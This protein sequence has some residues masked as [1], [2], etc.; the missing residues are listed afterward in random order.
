ME[1]Y[2]NAVSDKLVVVL[3]EN[4][5]IY[6]VFKKDNLLKWK[7]VRHGQV[8]PKQLKDAIQVPTKAMPTYYLDGL[9]RTLLYVHTHTPH[10]HTPHT[11]EHTHTHTQRPLCSD[12]CPSSTVVCGLLQSEVSSRYIA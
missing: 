3:F 8:I 12:L 4:L 6:Q 5:T 10:H 1:S 9:M 7:T 11:Q 2:H